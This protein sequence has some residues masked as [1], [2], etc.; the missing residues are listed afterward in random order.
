MKCLAIETIFKFL[1]S[2]IAVIVTISIFITFKDNIINFFVPKK[3]E[4]YYEIEILELKSENQKIFDSLLEI[5]AQKSFNSSI[6][7]PCYYVYREKNKD[8]SFLSFPETI[9]INGIGFYIN[10]SDFNSNK[11]NLLIISDF[12]KKIIYIK[13]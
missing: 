3:L 11:N 13:N 9:E 1:I 12:N 6:P 2:M 5:C 4:K 8:F 10:I 7:I